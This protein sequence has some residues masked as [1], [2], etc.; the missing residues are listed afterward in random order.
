MTQVYGTP[1][2]YDLATL[3]AVVAGYL[4]TVL[5][6]ACYISIGLWVS[7]HTRNAIVALIGSTLLCGTLY[8]LMQ[9]QSVPFTFN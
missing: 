8:F 2:R 3:I 1:R 4:A 9:L 6:G 7:A 5:L